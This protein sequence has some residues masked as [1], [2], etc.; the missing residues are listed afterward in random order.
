MTQVLIMKNALKNIVLAIG[1]TFAIATP[2]H[3]AGCFVDYK[4]KQTAN[5]LKLHYGVMQLSGGACGNRSSAQQFVS[6][7]L[8][9][10]GWTLLTILSILDANGAKQRQGNAG[11]YFLRY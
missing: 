6:A 7:R 8:A 4:A 1:L 9:K 10:N 11:A 3:A 5:G 2:S